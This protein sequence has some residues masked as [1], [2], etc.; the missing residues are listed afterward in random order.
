MDPPKVQTG[1]S[2]MG[3][4][5]L[6]GTTGGLLDNPFFRFLSEDILGTDNSDPAQLFGT[7]AF[8]SSHQIVQV[9]DDSAAAVDATCSGVRTESLSLQAQDLQAWA[10]PAVTLIRIDQVRS[11]PLFAGVDGHGQTI[12]IIDS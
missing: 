10:Q 5:K 8:V 6:L 12:V 1:V 2:V 3:I 11:D 7:A 9:P 4:K